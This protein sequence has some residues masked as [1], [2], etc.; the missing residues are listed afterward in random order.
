MIGLNAFP[1]KKFPFQL[2]HSSAVRTT[3]TTTTTRIL[4][5]SF[6]EQFLPT[7]TAIDSSADTTTT[8]AS[9]P[10]I[11]VQQLYRAA[12]SKY[13]PEK[14]IKPWFHFKEWKNET[15]NPCCWTCFIV[16]PPSLSKLWKLKSHGGIYSS[17]RILDAYSDSIDMNKLQRNRN[18]LD[19]LLDSCGE[20]W[21]SVEIQPAAPLSTSTSSSSSTTLTRKEMIRFKSKRGAEKCAALNLLFAIEMGRL[22]NINE[23]DESSIDYEGNHL[24]AVSENSLRTNCGAHIKERDD[25]DDDDDDVIMFHLHK[26]QYYGNTQNPNDCDYLSRDNPCCIRCVVSVLC[27]AKNGGNDVRVSDD[28]DDA[29]LE[30]TSGWHNNAEDSMHDAFDKLNCKL[31]TMWMSSSSFSLGKNCANVENCMCHILSEM[32]RRSKST[33][34]TFEETLPKWATAKI[35]SK[36]YLHELEFSIV[37]NCGAEQGGEDIDDSRRTSLSKFIQLDDDV[38]TRVGIICGCASLEAGLSAEFEWTRIADDDDD[39]QHNMVHVAISNSTKVPLSDMKKQLDHISPAFE[40]GECPISLMKC[41][42]NVLFDYGKRY[43]M[44]PKPTWNELYDAVTKEN[45]VEPGNSRS[46]MFVPLRPKSKEAHANP[47]IDW[48]VVYDVVHQKTTT[49]VDSTFPSHLLNHFIIQP[50]GFGGRV[51]VAK[52]ELNVSETPSSPLL[53]VDLASQLSNQIEEKMR[54]AFPGSELS[55]ISH[56]QYFE[57]VHQYSIKYPAELLVAARTLSGLKYEQHEFQL[58]QR[59]GGETQMTQSIETIPQNSISDILTAR[60][61]I[62]PEL[63]HIL[64][65]PRDFLYMCRRASIFMPKLERAHILQKVALRFRELQKNAAISP[66][67]GPVPS[68]NLLSLIEMATTRGIINN[69]GKPLMK[70][71]HERLETLGDSVLLHF[72]VL[73]LFA[74]VSSTDGDE[75]I[76]DIFDRV[77]TIQGKNEILF[78]AAMQIGLHRLIHDG[79]VSKSSWRSKY[80]TVK[81]SSA[82]IDVTQKQLSDTVESI[83]GATYLADLSGTMTVGFLNQ[84]GP[85]FPDSFDSNGP[86]CNDAIGWFAASGTCLEEG[87]PF[88]NHPRWVNELEQIQKIMKC[89]PDIYSTLQRNTA[90]FLEMLANRKSQDRD[91]IAMLKADPFALLLIH[92]ALFD[93]SLDGG[94]EIRDLVKIAQLRD[95]IFNVGNAALQ[96]SIVSELY[97]LYPVSTSGDFHLMK[98]TLMSN[99]VLAYVFVTNGFHTFLFDADATDVMQDY[100]NEADRLGGKEWIKNGGWIIPGGVEEFRKRIHRCGSEG[101]VVNPRYMGLA[102]GRL[103]GHRRK[104]P[105]EASDDLQFSMKCTV[106]AIALIFGVHDAWSLFRPFFLELLVLSPEE[107]RT[108]FKGVSD[109]VGSYQKGKR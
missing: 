107:L 50:T 24:A 66:K 90:A 42:N 12:Q 76:Q 10:I 49:V 14:S 53:S 87:F 29:I 83:I 61:F 27:S 7:Q 22:D 108:S 80:Q 67:S 86:S 4:S 84:I 54:T 18:P 44:G 9:N 101:L 47:S 21:S 2:H 28:G 97:H 8:T 31:H 48:Q 105:P 56:V 59:L 45:N 38:A 100:I 96:M 82:A 75:F 94:S 81:S 89:Y 102:A 103:L 68:C 30:V 15:N 62:V 40:E 36:M 69:S 98:T 79:S 43:G 51:F 34:I 23:L 16:V 77:I 41:F 58:I 13:E 57:T 32:K 88:L 106:G 17:G 63:I 109:L 65:L 26:L 39:A 71:D 91:H 25:D 92:S 99:D 35:E 55:N 70:R 74:K 19:A 72:I 52:K 60:G 73:N 11:L 85:D 5:S 46:Y 93:D 95:K 1:C 104:L 3:T 64:P 20:W 33:I 37:K 6:L 78:N